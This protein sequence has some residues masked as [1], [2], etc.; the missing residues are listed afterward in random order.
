M[1]R[2]SQKKRY[3]SFIAGKHS[4]GSALNS[5][6]NT[7]RILANVDLDTSG[8]LSRRLGVDYEKDFVL[9]TDSFT[10]DDIKSNGIHFYE[11][12]TVNED[13]NRNFLVV[14]FGNI[15]YFYNPTLEPLSGGLVGSLDIS[16]QTDDATGAKSLELQVISGR[17]VLFVTG[18]L[19]DPFFV[20]FDPTDDSFT[21][22]PI[23]IKIRDFEGVEDGLAVDTRPVTLSELHDYN[24]QNQGWRAS[25]INQVAFPSNADI[26]HLGIKTDSNGDLI[27]DVNT[28]FA[29]TFGN[30]RAPN[31]HFVLDAF[32]PNRALVSGIPGL[33]VSGTLTRPKSTA[34]FS[35]RVWFGAVK[36]KIYFS[37]ILEQLDKAGNCFQDQDP[38]S[39]SFNE[40]LD[41]DGGVLVIPEM[42]ICHKLVS[43]GRSLLVMA[44]NGIWEISGGDAPF[45]ANN[46]ERRRV[47]EVGTV[48]GESVVKA[49]NRVY[50][51]SEEGI[52][53]VTQDSVTGLLAAVS[54]SDNRINRDYN[55][56]P[57]IAR[58]FAQGNYD[59]V[60]K[61]VY[62]SYHDSL[63]DDSSNIQGKY[64]SCLIY[65]TVLNSFWDYRVEDI[66]PSNFSPFMAGLVKRGA[67]NEG[68]V[69]NLVVEQDTLVTVNG[70]EVATTSSFTSV[71][72]VPIKILTFAPEGSTTT[73][74]I[75]FSEF[76]SRSF[77]DW[78]SQ[79]SKGKNYNSVIETNPETLGDGVLDKQAT[80][81]TT[82]YDF[83]RQGFGFLGA[84][85][86]PD[87]S[88]G[89]RIT[90]NC[91][92]VLRKGQPNLRVT[93]NSIEVLRGD[94]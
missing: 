43:V 87:P 54:L 3:L 25:R 13:G 79:D 34:F 1:A 65:D 50:F 51:W 44:S 58:F 35:G 93:Q 92:E 20:E 10:E 14:R 36:G 12:L 82:F 23:D 71:A 59:R 84:T 88:T 86:R 49:E 85:P 5:P 47:S 2:V 24:L 37:Q 55:N 41:T 63:N 89:L 40:L 18:E 30:T 15:L 4:D 80:Y 27:F 8:L 46:A 76:C 45:T 91:I 74:K 62:W 38:T 70:V 19:Y 6:E 7:A 57:A 9:S 73:R 66:D 22:V 21:I 29:Q 28:L 26:E 81:L 64:N 11:W 77:H 33:P 61:R 69:T 56:I 68:Q 75:T 16:T 48:G 42:G 31:G 78:F 83:Q 67:R 32:N 94:L 39:E 53:V 17:G 60:N 90:Q 72:E 52:F